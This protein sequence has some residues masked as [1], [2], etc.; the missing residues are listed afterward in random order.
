MNDNDTPFDVYPA[1]MVDLIE[2]HFLGIARYLSEVQDI[3]PDSFRDVVRDRNI[4]QRKGYALARIDRKFHS[5]GVPIE[6]LRKLSWTKLAMLS[7]YVDEGTVEKLL[8]L[9]EAEILGH[10]TLASSQNSYNQANSFA[11]TE[12]YGENIR[13][14][15]E[16]DNQ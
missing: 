9:A 14:L 8:E 6:R 7:G 3:A 15:I 10:A 13:R 5:I 12:A 4:G 2:D 1:V 11:A 16:G